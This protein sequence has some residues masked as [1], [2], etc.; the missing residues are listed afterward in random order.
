[1]LALV[2]RS[3]QTSSVSNVVEWEYDKERLSE[4]LAR[5]KGI[6]PPATHQDLVDNSLMDLLRDPLAWGKEDGDTGVFTGWAGT[7][8]LIVYV[9]NPDSARVTVVDINYA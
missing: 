1:M 8:I 3:C 4:A 9:P 2:V 5:W 7:V 6:K